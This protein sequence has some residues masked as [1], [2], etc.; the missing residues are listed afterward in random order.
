M[1]IS[2]EV[3]ECDFYCSQSNPF[4]D[5]G[6]DVFMRN[7]FEHNSLIVTP[8]CIPSSLPASVKHG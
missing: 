3:F 1:K 5:I 8:F 6:R 2:F 7:V 4:R